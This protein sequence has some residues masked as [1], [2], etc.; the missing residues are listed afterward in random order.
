[1][2]K[3]PF[4]NC[5]Q[6]KTSIAKDLEFLAPPGSHFS[7]SIRCP[8]CKTPVPIRVSVSEA[9]VIQLSED[10]KTTVEGEEMVAKHRGGAIRTL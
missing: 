9:V 2:I 10:V 8:N 1:M 5:K 7:M 4:I 6:C 3:I